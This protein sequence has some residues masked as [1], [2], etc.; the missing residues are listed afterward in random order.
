MLI[1]NF[2]YDV[3]WYT[4]LWLILIYQGSDVIFNCEV[5]VTD[6][7]DILYYYEIIDNYDNGTIYLNFIE[8]TPYF[9]LRTISS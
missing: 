3:N 9:V 6:D 2:F 1:Q 5:S 4:F 8:T 7:Y